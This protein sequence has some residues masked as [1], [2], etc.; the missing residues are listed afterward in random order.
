MKTIQYIELPGK[1][2]P[3]LGRN[4]PRS[5][6]RGRA[7]QK[8]FVALAVENFWTDLGSWRKSEIG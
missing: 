2:N 5:K 7:T 6:P 1:R 4:S 8:K 3:V